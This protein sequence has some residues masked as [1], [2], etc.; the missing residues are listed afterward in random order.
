MAPKMNSGAVTVRLAPPNL[1][2]QQVSVLLAFCFEPP[3]VIG[4]VS[5]SAQIGFACS[6][7]LGQTNNPVGSEVFS[8]HESAGS[9][10]GSSSAPRLETA[11][12]YQAVRS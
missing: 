12:K 1:V 10:I 7:V 11:S 6:L 5:L 3:Y 8:L 4:S 2:P 9:P